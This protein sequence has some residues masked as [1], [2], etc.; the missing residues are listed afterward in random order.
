MAKQVLN[1][2][3]ANND[4]TGDT[5]RA[6]GIKIKSNFEEIYTALA[7]DGINISGGNLLKT[8]DYSDLINKPSFSN[9]AIS[10]D[11]YDLSNRPDLG[12]F[13][14]APPNN[15][16][17][18]G[19]VAGNMAFDGLNLYVCREDYI[20]QDQF[21]NFIFSHEHPDINFSLQARFSNTTN[22]VALK[23]ENPLAGQLP[24]QED[25][26]ITDGTVVRTITSVSLELDVD[27]NPYYLCTLD[28]SFVSVADTYYEVSFQ[29]P[30][31][32]YAFSAE[33]KPE[34]QDLVDAHVLGQD[35]K[36]Y[37]TYDGYGRNVQHIIHDSFADEITIS[38]QSGSNIADFDGIIIKLNQPEIWKSVPWAP[39]YGDPFPSGGAANLGS[40]KIEDNTLGTT[41]GGSGWGGSDINLSPN[42]ES[43]S[44]ISIPNDTNSAGGSALTIGN[45]PSTS[46]GVQLSVN[47]KYWT[48]KPDGSL[49][50]PTL[51]VNLHNGG[52]Q[53]G[54]VLKFG[55]PDQ[56]AI[57]T[58][59][60][61]AENEN[62]QRLIVQGQKATGTGEGGDVYFWAGDSQNYGGD[63][64]IYAGDADSTTSGYGGYIN[65]DA[66]RGYTDGG[67]ISI[68]AGDAV[69]DVLSAQGGHLSLSAGNSY[70]QTGNINIATGQS[71]GPDS[72]PGN[73][74]L[75]AYNYGGSYN[76]SFDSE[77][78]ITFPDGSV[79]TTAYTGATSKFV[80]VNQSGTV[81]GSTDGVS[82]TGPYDTTLDLE[83]VAVGPNMVVYCADTPDGDRLYYANDWN[84]APTQ[85]TDTGSAVTWSQVRYFADIGHFVAVGRIDGT[86]TY[87]HSSNGIDWTIVSL[88]NVW[89]ATLN[90]GDGPGTAR[91]T[92]IATNGTGF[93][94]TT[95][96]TVLGS[97]YTTTLISNSNIGSGDW[98]DDGMSF[99]EVV[100]SSTGDF[101]GWFGFGVGSGSISDSWW[102]NNSANPGGGSFSNAWGI[103]SISA[104]FANYINYEPSW[105]ELAIGSAGGLSTVVIA[106]T[107]GQILYWPAVAAG[108][109][110]SIPKPYTSSINDIARGTTTTISFT[111]Y[112]PAADGEKITITGVTTHDASEPGTSDQSYNGTFYIKNNSG[113]YELYTDT[114][115]TIPLDTTTYWPVDLD[116]GTITWSHGQFIDALN[117]VNGKFY[118]GNDDEE[119][120]VS[121]NGGATWAQVASLT[122]PSGEGEALG[123]M[124]DMDGYVGFGSANT[125]DITFDGVKIIGAGTASGD[126]YGYGTMELVPDNN[127][128]A[129]APGGTYGSGGG[130]YLIIDPTSPQH[131]H[132]RAGGPIDEAA[133][134]LILGGEKANVTVRDQNNSYAQEHHVIINT[135][136]NDTTHHNWKFGNDGALTLPGII[137]NSS[138]ALTGSGDPAYPTALDLT[139]TINKLSDNTGSNYTLADGTEGQI[140]YL[141]PKDGATNV[142]VYIMVNH[143]RVLNNSGSTTAAVFTDIAFNPFGT[144]TSMTSNVVTMIFTDGAWQSSG[145][146][147]D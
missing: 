128:Y 38:Y 135:E 54:Q 142:G 73:I 45:S 131:V 88:D 77:G 84:I 133:A 4:K 136:S 125:G 58:G 40:F 141:V 83:R 3:T 19:H 75:T 96:N 13:V 17:V 56:Q 76:W 82:W 10:G 94:L 144:D 147:W 36:L 108:P 113:D 11:F 60:T 32:S 78:A 6:G 139:K 7:S 1:V 122:G 100:Y 70:R 130:Q 111:D 55:N 21:T 105:S 29:L 99:T 24:P 118:A 28:G 52:D 137:V 37:V 87:K 39:T 69:G 50:T 138:Q 92:D 74:N 66:G 8:G 107:A 134:V 86:P 35:S 15:A 97:F 42:G 126:G 63:I 80:M 48:F 104:A 89:A 47:S 22:D 120:F 30:A 64:K 132:I 121:S 102:Y 123:Y 5:L 93:I 101:T 33:W 26:T 31:G 68:S 46:G 110:V 119:V 62:A 61:P 53:S 51:T 41:N 114:A 72:T 85:V 23:I 49:Y 79:Q 143:G 81:W 98:I 44:W 90:G 57:I 103:T 115:L 34:Y 106:T 117:Y 14:G 12:I 43:N 109:Y 71:Y 127:L 112:A 67:D 25:W 124:A 65:I 2:G 20:Q 18:D 95:D 145:G 16:G 129:I 146:I 9:V 91:F 116:T 140:M 59:P 27:N